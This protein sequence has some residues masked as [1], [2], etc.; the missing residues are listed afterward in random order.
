MLLDLMTNGSALYLCLQERAKK[1]IEK[2]QGHPLALATI[3][4]AIDSDRS[5][6]LEEWDGVYDNFL[7]VLHS[8]E[9]TASILG[10]KHSKSFWTTMQ[11]SIQ[12]LG[13]NARKLLI[14]VHMCAGPSVPEEV[15]RSLYTRAV[16]QA[17]FEAFNKA[18]RE[19]ASRDLIKI[20]HNVKSW[21]TLGPLLNLFMEKEMKDGKESMFTVLV[22]GPSNTESIG[23]PDI[24]AD[25][26][27][28][29]DA[30]IQTAICALYFDKPFSARAASNMDIPSDRLNDLRRNAIEPI[31]RLLGRS[32][33]ER[34]TAASQ[35]SAE[36]VRAA[37]AQKI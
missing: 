11:L 26:V 17:D 31:T 13:V 33:S 29:N 3:A 19:L 2:C 27:R 1:I 6:D 20:I 23:K 12:S 10:K 15:L 16:V 5:D 37:Q 30:M 22:P 8:T 9:D 24:N 4:T 36:Q 7:H 14:L 21:L 32:I 28:N 34:W 25:F 35:A 18:R